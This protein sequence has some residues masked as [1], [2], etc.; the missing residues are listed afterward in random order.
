MRA[1]S[2]PTKP[3]TRLDDYHYPKEV[4]AQHLHAT[5]TMPRLVRTINGNQGNFLDPSTGK[6]FTLTLGGGT[7]PHGWFLADVTADSVVIEILFDAW[8]MLAYLSAGASS[9]SRTIRKPVG[10]LQGIRQW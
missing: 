5:L 7:G 9:P 2:A 8:G 4:Q 6:T 1:C 3:I 10:R